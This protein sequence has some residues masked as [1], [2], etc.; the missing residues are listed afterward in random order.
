MEEVP[1]R[2]LLALLASSCFVPCLIGVETEGLLDYQGRAGII[3]IA[4]WNLRTVIL[5]V[6]I[7]EREEESHASGEVRAS[8]KVEELEGAYRRR[9]GFGHRVQERVQISPLETSIRRAARLLI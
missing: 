8:R 3:S 7:R 6:E 4:R 5:G 1:R 2:T 9:W